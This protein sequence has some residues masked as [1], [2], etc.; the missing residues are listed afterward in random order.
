MMCTLLRAVILLP[1]DIHSQLSDFLRLFKHAVKMPSRFSG[2]PLSVN[3]TLRSSSMIEN[4]EYTCLGR[5][6]WIMIGCNVTESPPAISSRLFCCIAHVPDHSAI[7]RGKK[8]RQ[9]LA[10]QVGSSYSPADFGG[11]G[12]DLQLQQREERKYVGIGRAARVLFRSVDHLTRFQI[13]ACKS[14]SD[15]SL[16][17]RAADTG[18]YG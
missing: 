14:A 18:I 3:R 12:T 13:G 16:Q 9:R 4:R 15:R 8:A 2:G 11:W 5:V 6:S 10:G 7:A 17:N 1:H